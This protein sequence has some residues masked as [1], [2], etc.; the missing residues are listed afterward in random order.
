MIELREVTRRFGHVVALNGVSISIADGE[1]VALVGPSGSGKTTLLR[2]INGMIAPDAGTVRVSADRA[3]IGMVY[4]QFNLVPR[5]NVA[6]NVQS[7]RIGQMSNA[8]VL[9]SFMRPKIEPIREVLGKLGIADKIRT[10][11]ERLSG[12]EQQRVA[13][14]RALFQDPE[15]LLADE[16]ISSVDPSL[17]QWI[18]D[19]LNDW[20]RT[21]RATLVVSLHQVEFARANFDR[22]IGVRAGVIAFD[23]PP[24]G[25]SDNMLS[26]LYEN[27]IVRTAAH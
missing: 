17:S 11:T 5:L 19:L 18:I 3:Q 2:I 10:R 7:G 12:G 13:I 20:A 25:V 23:M 1:R 24:A 15:I 27:E 26:D 9:W 22:I 4:Q 6:R 14:A 21:K 16:P 8:R